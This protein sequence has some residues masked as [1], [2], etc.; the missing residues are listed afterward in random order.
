M[1]E[2]YLML[3]PNT[4]LE[5]GDRRWLDVGDVVAISKEHELH[6]SRV[7]YDDDPSDENQIILTEYVHGKACHIHTVRNEHWLLLPTRF[8]YLE[9]IPK[10]IAFDRLGNIFKMLVDIKQTAASGMGFDVGQQRKG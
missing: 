9:V 7:R 4:S 6:V 10:A 5:N 3:N 2:I 1:A 8:G